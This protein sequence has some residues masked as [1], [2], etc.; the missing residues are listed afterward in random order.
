MKYK[1]IPEINLF[2]EQVKKDTGINIILYEDVPRDEKGFLV[3][4]DNTISLKIDEGAYWAHTYGKDREINKKFHSYLKKND[5]YV[6]WIKIFGG[7][8]VSQ[9]SL[10]PARNLKE[11]G[12]I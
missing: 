11:F 4:E 2:I 12:I 8:K 3:Y 10:T 6:F 9:L 1:D 5:Y 7:H